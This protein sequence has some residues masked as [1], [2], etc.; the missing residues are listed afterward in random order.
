MTMIAL[1]LSPRISRFEERRRW[2]K[3]YLKQKAM[4]EVDSRMHVEC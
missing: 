4:N 2:R 1:N 3:V